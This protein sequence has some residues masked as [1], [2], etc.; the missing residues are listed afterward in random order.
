[1]AD[2][3]IFSF[4]KM[5]KRSTPRQAVESKLGTSLI[6]KKEEEDVFSTLETARKFMQTSCGQ[7]AEPLGRVHCLYR[8]RDGHDDSCVARQA[9]HVE[10]CRHESTEKGSFQRTNEVIFVV[11][12]K[13][14]L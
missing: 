2:L 12:R 14:L 1:M 8:M 3:T 4:K 11:V 5:N 13:G 6:V 7:K 10:I 9:H